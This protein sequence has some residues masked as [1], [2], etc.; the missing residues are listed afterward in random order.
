V[1]ARVKRMLATGSL[2]RCRANGSTSPVNTSS[3]SESART[4]HGDAQGGQGYVGLGMRS[5]GISVE[6]QR[7][8]RGR[9]T[10]MV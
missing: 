7:W 9:R 10:W 6:R 5:R 4:C 2:D 1:R 8:S 3:V